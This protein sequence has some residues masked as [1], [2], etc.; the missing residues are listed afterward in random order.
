MVRENQGEECHSAH[1]PNSGLIIPLDP[2]PTPDPLLLHVRGKEYQTTVTH[3]FIQH[4]KPM[5]TY[6]DD[7]RTASSNIE[8]HHGLRAQEQL[9][10]DGWWETGYACSLQ[11]Y[12]CQPIKQNLINWAKGTVGSM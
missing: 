9:V 3:A 12:E 2:S 1:F 8:H 7:A 10:G 5:M 6:T 11:A 4:M